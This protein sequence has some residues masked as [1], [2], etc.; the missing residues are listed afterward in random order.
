MLFNKV[1]FS[2]LKS[3]EPMRLYHTM[4]SSDFYFSKTHNSNMLPES[5]L[6]L[7]KAAVV[8][9]PETCRQCE[10]FKKYLVYAFYGRPAFRFDPHKEYEEPYPIFFVFDP[11]TQE[12][13]AAIYPFDTGAFASGLYGT[14][15]ISKEIKDYALANNGEGLSVSDVA[16][17]VQ[18]I[19]GNNRNYYYGNVP[20]N[21]MNTNK[22]IMLTEL[23]RNYLSVI[24][25][26]LY[27]TA[28]SRAFTVEFI[29]ERCLPLKSLQSIYLPNAITAEEI[30][31]IYEKIQAACGHE[32]W[33]E[34]L[35]AKNKGDND[36]PADPFTAMLIKE[37]EQFE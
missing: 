13:P 22:N 37:S 16:K 14:A 26:K 7:A 2:T 5:H 18:Q 9:E 6:D 1:D 36:L 11:D 28:D 17:L 23:D 35:S 4:R 20:Q 21:R 10:V 8:S 30:C 24:Y 34:A 31:E 29:Y 27:G 33:V 12:Q 3:N 32:V 25:E 15:Y 19:W